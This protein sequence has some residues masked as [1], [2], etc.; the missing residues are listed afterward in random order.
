MAGALIERSQL[1][2]ARGSR[3]AIWIPGHCL[4]VGL[5]VQM[6]AVVLLIICAFGSQISLCVSA[7]PKG[8][9]EAQLLPMRFYGADDY[10][11]SQELAYLL[12]L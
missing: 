5:K 10:R 7:L 4:E 8:N 3:W 2:P 1:H 9:A 6:C 12:R 11:K